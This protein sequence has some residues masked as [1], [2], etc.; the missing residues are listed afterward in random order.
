MQNDDV[1]RLC[2][3][4][5]PS[6]L[7]GVSLEYLN[8]KRF[9]NKN[10]SF[11][12]L[13]VISAVKFLWWEGSIPFNHR[14]MKLWQS[15]KQNAFLKKDTSM[16]K[17]LVGQLHLGQVTRGQHRVEEVT[18][19]QHSVVHVLSGKVT[20]GQ[21]RFRHIKSGIQGLQQITRG[22]Y[23]V[24]QNTIISLPAATK[25]NHNVIAVTRGRFSNHN[26]FRASVH[27]ENQDRVMLD[28][29]AAG[30]NC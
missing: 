4:V 21:H 20:G 15:Q 6:C 25:R 5:W 13:M 10:G 24:K 3:I 22:Q 29:H 9:D 7:V 19:G 26:H 1:W 28:H 18:R 30:K 11:D 27:Q 16:V 2:N 23:R 12:F 17:L 8:D 14:V